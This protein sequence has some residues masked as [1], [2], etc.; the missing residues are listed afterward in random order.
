MSTCNYLIPRIISEDQETYAVPSVSLWAGTP[1][2][3][4]KEL[5]QYGADVNGVLKSEHSHQLLYFTVKPR[6]VNLGTN[7]ETSIINSR[8][9]S[10]KHH[11]KTSHSVK[12]L[13]EPRSAIKSGTQSGWT[14]P[15]QTATAASEMVPPPTGDSGIYC[16]PPSPMTTST[17]HVSE[18]ESENFTS[19]RLLSRRG[20]TVLPGIWSL[21]PPGDSQ[22][23]QPILPAFRRTDSS[24]PKTVPLSPPNVSCTVPCAASNIEAVP[25]APTVRSSP[26]VVEID[27]TKDEGIVIDDSSSCEVCIIDEDVMIVSVEE[28][29]DAVTGRGFVSSANQ[30]PVVN[31]CGISLTQNDLDTLRPHQWLN[32]QVRLV[33]CNVCL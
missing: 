7:E 32:D 22:E 16:T 6:G 19:L 27:L 20:D 12:D 29:G 18:T 17:D 24:L 9:C 8:N 25:S 23:E 21:H 33:M 4:A 13:T 1:V 5:L 3:T 30:I 10:I 26:D 11:H 2:L 15:K 14:T 31:C 28:R